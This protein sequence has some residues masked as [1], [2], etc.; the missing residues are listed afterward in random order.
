[1]APS[2]F[3]RERSIG[4]NNGE[5]AGAEGKK[6]E[7]EHGWH[8]IV[9]RLARTPDRHQGSMWKLACGHKEVI[10]NRSDDHRH[11]MTAKILG[12]ASR[13]SAAGRKKRWQKLAVL[14]D[15]SVL[16]AVEDHR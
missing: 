4:S 8:S 14:T 5:P 15:A 2:Q 10:K 13:L 12:F 1:M 11:A 6:H 7:V 16:T 3:G 9:V